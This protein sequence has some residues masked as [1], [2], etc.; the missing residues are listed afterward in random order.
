M[1]TKIKAQTVKDTRDYSF[2]M[3]DDAELPAPAKELPSRNTSVHNS[4]KLLLGC[5]FVWSL[6][7]GVRIYFTVIQVNLYRAFVCF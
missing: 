6:I 3:S 7:V 1:Q 4:G 2:L 5:V